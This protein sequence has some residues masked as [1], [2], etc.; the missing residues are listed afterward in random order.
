MARFFARW[1][2][3]ADWA[4]VPASTLSRVV[5]PIPLGPTIA[6]RDP[7]GTVRSRPAKTSSPPKDLPSL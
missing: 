1:I 3:P 6:I 7:S 2:V 5:L 4:S